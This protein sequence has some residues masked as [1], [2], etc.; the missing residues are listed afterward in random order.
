MSG[1]KMTRTISRE[2]FHPWRPEKLI[3]VS[4][5]A[6]SEGQR[7][8]NV[9][10]CFCMWLRP[11]E[12]MAVVLL[13]FWTTE[14]S[15]WQ[16]KERTDRGYSK[17]QGHHFPYLLCSQHTWKQRWLNSTLGYCNDARAVQSH[18]NTLHQPIWH[19]PWCS[20]M[21]GEE[22]AAKSSHRVVIFVAF[23]CL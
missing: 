6:R 2:S 14:D 18:T 16:G 7:S 5:Q 21:S 20:F 15:C 4:L 8:L 17:I 10:A 1:K 3:P 11:W 12:K 19:D 13:R 23:S 22:G 9:N